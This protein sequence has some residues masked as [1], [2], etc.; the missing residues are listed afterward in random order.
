[1]TLIESKARDVNVTV[2]APSVA[3][4]PER[5]RFEWLFAAHALFA[6]R[7]EELAELDQFAEQTGGYLFVTASSGLGKTA[8][9]VNWVRQLEAEGIGLAYAFVNRLAG[10]AGEEIIFRVLCQQLAAVHGETGLLPTGTGE[11][12]AL[13][14]RLLTIQPPAGKR[15]VVV[16]DGLDEADGWQPK[17]D[18]FPPRLP[19]GVA[20][21]FS[22]REIADQDWLGLLGF[23]GRT[24]ERLRLETLDPTEIGQILAAAGEALPAWARKPEV[25]GEVHSVSGGDPLYVRLLIDDLRP[26]SEGRI[27]IRSLE[28]LRG[29]PSGLDGYFDGWWEQ[30]MEARRERPELGDAVR[31]LLGY[32]LVAKGPLSR[33]DLSDLSEEDALDDFSVDDALALVRRQ[34][35]GTPET[36]F[37]LAH[38]R[39]QSYLAEKRLREKVQRDYRS[40][41]LAYC[42]RWAE[43]PTGY[44]LRYYAAHLAD[45][46]RSEELFALARNDQFAAAQQRQLPSEPDLPVRVNELA[47]QA[48]ADSDD[49]PGMAEFAT[50]KALKVAAT[51]S[52]YSPIEALRTVGL[53]AAWAVADLYDDDRRTRFHLLLAWEL[54]EAGRNDEARA[55]LDRLSHMGATSLGFGPDLAILFDE[56][57]E[58]D[59]G[60]VEVLESLVPGIQASRASLALQRVEAQ[61][62]AGELA[63]A[64]ATADAIGDNSLRADAFRKLALAQAQA[65][66]TEEARAS[67]DAARAATELIDDD[68]SRV[69][70]LSGLAVIQ[71]QAGEFVAAQQTAEGIADDWFRAQALSGLA[72]AQAQAGDFGAAQQI[73]EL[74]EDERARSVALSGLAVAQAQKGDFAAAYRTVE[75]I[76]EEWF[77]AQALSGLAVAQAQEGDFVASRRTGKGIANEWFR[78][79]ALSGLVVAQAQAGDVKGARASFVA[80]K[81]AAAKIDDEVSRVE[82]LSRLAVAQA[83]AGDAKG[84]Q[85]SFAVAK[86]AT[87][88]IDYYD[89]EA[90]ALTT[91]SEAE[92]HAGEFAAAQA[93]AEAIHDTDSRALALVKVASAQ[94]QEGAVEAARASFAAAQEAADA[95]DDYEGFNEEGSERGNR[96]R[97]EVLSAL[98]V[99]QAEAGEFTAAHTTAESVGEYDSRVRA[100]TELAI[101]EVQAGATAE[102]RRNFAAAQATEAIDDNGRRVEELSWLAVAQAHTGDGEGARASFAAARKATEGIVSDQRRFEALTKLASA[103]AQAGDAEGARAC[104]AA[105]RTAAETFRWDKPW[106]LAR[107]AVA[108]AQEGE[109]NAAKA[110][111]EAIEDDDPRTVALATL[112]AA[113][114]MAE[115]I[116]DG[117]LR[118]EALT[119]LAFAQA[120]AGNDEAARAGFA[121]AQQAAEKIRNDVERTNALRELAVAQAQAGFGADALNTVQALTHQGEALASVAPSLAEAGEPADLKLTLGVCANYRELIPTICALLTC[122][123]PEQELPLV[124]R[125]QP[126]LTQQAT[127]AS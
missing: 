76:P 10:H 94:A 16:L 35:I 82:L 45:A 97:A 115:G 85:A 74:I 55:T 60:L 33:D 6:G 109:F 56:V 87:E 75:A 27:R 11:L 20:V 47:F 72:V 116:G 19:D 108:Q 96:S 111:A 4:A 93:T 126:L 113:Q 43:H 50:R 68:T 34:T 70:A 59:G 28:E 90:S 49:A 53:S 61:S 120:R 98:A 100:L 80:A 67:F 9:L 106:A 51:R 13:Y 104:F 64:L 41:L 24:V 31:D 101:A 54:E 23:H 14:L 44:A 37:A 17:P 46:G 15:V 40:R 114:Q 26:D 121:D 83:H 21:V 12:R 86:K 102:A 105:A 39:F 25:A 22:A 79:E 119:G 18:L 66:L 29:Q 95:I 78:A 110:T 2:V 92:A 123:Y 42:G 3:E 122:A 52:S 7:D 5:V 107:L 62:R 127:E 58:I 1:M 71:A 77:R 38:P 81:A 89:S 8:L 63:A 84:A 36:G 48:A 73:G 30:I 57:R 124:A 88:A 118:A 112:A 32:L 69:N 65:G 117:W 91:L 125:V 99:A 103:Q